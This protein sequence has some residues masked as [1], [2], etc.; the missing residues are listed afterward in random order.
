MAS[1]PQDSDWLA[2]IAKRAGIGEEE[3]K[4]ALAAE[5]IVASPAPGKPRR[6][7]LRGLR[8]SGVKVGVPNDGEFE[9]VWEPLEHGLYGVVTERNQRGKS[10]IIEIIRW[11]L[12]G[13]PSA[14]Q[15]DVYDWIHAAEL[16]FSL[17]AEVFAVRVAK[18]E[19]LSGA[20]VALDRGAERPVVVFLTENDFELAMAEFFLRE[21]SLEEMTVWT[22]VSGSVREKAVVHG[23]PALSGVLYVGTDYT[24]LLGDIPVGAGLSSRLLQMF[25]GL[26]W[27]ST[28]TVAKAALDGVQE[29]QKASQRREKDRLADRQARTEQIQGQLDAKRQ[30]RASLPG[31]ADLAE[32]YKANF[33]AIRRTNAERQSEEARLDDDQRALREAKQAYDD[34]RKELRAH[35]DA[36]AAGAIFRLIEPSRCPRCESSMGEDRKEREQEEHRCFVCGEDVQDEAGAD[37]REA[38]LKAARDA[39]RAAFEEAR[40]KESRR[41]LALEGIQQRRTEFVEALER[42][43]VEATASA[44]AKILDLEIAALEGQLKEL[45]YV[46]ERAE[47]APQEVSVLEAVLRETEALMKERQLELLEA[48]SE[49]MLDYARRFGIEALESLRLKGNLTLDVQ[50]G[51]SPTSYSKT[52][53]GEKLRLKVAAVLALIG[54]AESEGIGRHP[55]LLLIDSP[56]AQEVTP[57][58]LERLIAGL[59]D[60]SSELGH[61]QIVVASI[62][63]EAI[64]NHVPK[65][66]LR[67]AYG[68][69][70][71]W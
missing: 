1:P 12:R 36:V 20:L 3:V 37:E 21:L 11:L 53:P 13:R 46:A 54:V 70:A 44:G 22:R 64:V 4:A 15:A 10:S 28:A 31:G 56:A 42:L 62:A 69:E 71:L 26:P 39:S 24:S 2:R 65:E 35:L 59:D 41:L 63:S 29:E 38:E 43:D 19:G 57:H 32:R 50:K 61:L 68:D 33:E 47:E 67:A 14:L 48:V 30:D 34:D 49:K 58:D 45:L 27:V 51:G 52:T 17:D 5:R 7:L 60:I 16:V 25:L 23:W 8:F 18:K 66:H 55:G 6:L 9:F 40:E